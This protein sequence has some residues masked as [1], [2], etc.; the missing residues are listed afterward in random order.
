M[1]KL[2]VAIV[3]SGGGA[4]GAFHV[5]ALEYIHLHVNFRFPQLE[6]SLFSGS[7]TSTYTALML[8][9][10][11]YPEL[12]STWKSLGVE[13]RT[14]ARWQTAWKVL[15]GAGGLY[16]A[17]ILDKLVRKYVRLEDLKITVLMHLASLR[18]G[19]Y[20]TLSNTDFST[21]NDLQHAATASMRTPGYMDPVKS[22]NSR[23]GP[24][25]AVVDG[26]AMHARPIGE[27]LAY[28]PDII[29]ILSTTAFNPYERENTFKGLLRRP[30]KDDAISLAFSL[31]GEAAPDILFARDVKEFVRINHL[32]RNGSMAVTELNSSLK[33]MRFVNNVIVSPSTA[34]GDT[35]DYRKE[36]MVRRWNAGWMA[37]RD[38][39]MQFD[40]GLISADTT[41]PD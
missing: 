9:M 24:L 3:M 14:P 25:R 12:L 34:L 37:A 10:H 38:A 30:E 40:P 2:K 41:A 6:Y 11:K 26:S 17:G 39:F 16:G 23:Q 35:N 5:G 19:R 20:F 22:L 31:Y 4:R 15:R 33:P 36:T 28:D 7:S 21:T 32:L 18:D 27:V 8:A 29:F 13:R 1:E